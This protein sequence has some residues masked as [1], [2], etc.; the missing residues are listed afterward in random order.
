MKIA[1]R[2]ARVLASIVVLS[3]GI[4]SGLSI[5]MLNVAIVMPNMMLYLNQQLAWDSLPWFLSL[6]GQLL[7]IWCLLASSTL[8][9]IIAVTFQ[10]KAESIWKL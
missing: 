3:A 7:P 1:K 9:A 10:R 2:L 5:L 6:L 4:W 8:A